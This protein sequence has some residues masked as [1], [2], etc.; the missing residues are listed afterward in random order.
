MIDSDRRS[1]P[2]S[3]R[4]EGGTPV[5]PIQTM[6]HLMGP[7]AVASTLLAACTTIHRVPRPATVQEL[8]EM[9]DRDLGAGSGVARRGLATASVL[10]Q[11][12]DGSAYLVPVSVDLALAAIDSGGAAYDSSLLR[13]YEV[14]RTG[15]GALEGLGIGF[16]TGAVVGGL[17]GAGVGDWSSC[18][19]DRGGDCGVPG[20]YTTLGGA[21]IF[22]VP[23]A[24]VGALVGAGLRHT[25]RYLF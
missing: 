25:D 11:P 10:F 17:L 15:T 22:G 24:L 4:R 5:A 3:S 21:V 13:G 18:R 14:K 16:L 7:L 12:T 19:E 6:R 8:Q 9:T 23:L 1:G 2:A 20:E